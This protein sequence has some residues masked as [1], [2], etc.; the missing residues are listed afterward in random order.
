MIAAP[1][2]ASPTYAGAPEP[3]PPLP[4]VPGV[5]RR[6]IDA[7]GIRVHVAGHEWGGMIGCMQSLRSPRT[8]ELT[9][10]AGGW[11]RL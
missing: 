6:F 3:R 2:S 7:N 8:T 11:R 4:P 1:S 10:N 9:S 5:E